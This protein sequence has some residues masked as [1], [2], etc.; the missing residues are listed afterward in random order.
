MAQSRQLS[1]SAALLEELVVCLASQTVRN[2]SNS[3]E[4]RELNVRSNRAVSSAGSM[5]CAAQ[6]PQSFSGT[7]TGDYHIDPTQSPFL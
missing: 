6:G 2:T 4:Q 1:I 5:L 3:A 7:E